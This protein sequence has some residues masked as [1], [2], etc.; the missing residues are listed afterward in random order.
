MSKNLTTCLRAF[1]AILVVAGTQGA[2][3]G[4]QS[5]PELLTLDQAISLALRDNRLVKNSRLAV[6]KVDDQLA[7]TRKLRLPTFNLYALGAQQLVSLD[8]AFNKGV[9]GAFPATGPIPAQN[10]LITTPRR[11]IAVIA[12]SVSEPLSQQYRIRLNLDQLKLSRS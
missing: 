8:F 2:V 12:G 7:A 10:T 5:A 3:L 6:G 11:P 4:Q 1:L 9:F